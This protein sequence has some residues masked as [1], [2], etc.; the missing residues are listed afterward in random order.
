MNSTVMT[1][2]RKLAR[3]RAV[4]WWRA[5]VV[6]V[7][8]RLLL[9]RF[10]WLQVVRTTTTQTRAEDNRISLVPIVPNRGLIIDRNG[11][12]AGAQLLGL[13][14]GNHALQ[15]ARPR[16]HDR[17]AERRWSIS[18]P[19]TASASRSCSTRA[20][21]SNRCRSAPGSPTKRWPASSPSATAFP[22]SRSRRG[23]SATIRWA[24]FGS[25]VLGYIGR[26]NRPSDL[27]RIEESDRLRQLSRHRPHRQDRPRTAATNSSCT[28]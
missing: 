13:H 24:V 19:R 22:A 8:F 10:F 27:E 17:G 18:S 6:L 16:S 28:A 11:V 15:G 23:C 20:R 9:A 14:A 12:G 21:A 5:L 25:H 7:V 1:P 26:I 3:F 4:C 2:S